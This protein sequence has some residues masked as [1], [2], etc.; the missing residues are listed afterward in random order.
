MSSA[1]RHRQRA[2]WQRWLLV[3]VCCAVSL[4]APFDMDTVAEVLAGSVPSSPSLCTIS[5]GDDNDPD[6][7]TLLRPTK[8]PDFRCDVRKQPRLPGPIPPPHVRIGF[9]CWEHGHPARCLVTRAGSEHAFRNG[10]GAPLLC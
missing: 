6:E 2:T 7:D 3:L 9:R 1:C 10:C 5:N 8:G 4:I